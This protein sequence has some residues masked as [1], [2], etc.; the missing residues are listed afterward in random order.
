MEKLCSTGV[1]SLIVASSDVLFSGGDVSKTMYFLG[2]GEM[3]YFTEEFIHSAEVNTEEFLP[4]QWACEMTLWSEW[5]TIGTL[6]AR[7]DC[8]LTLISEEQFGLSMLS[9]DIVRSEAAVFVS[10]YIKDLRRIGR[11]RLTDI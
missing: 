7:L 2:E 6:Q 1:S 8:E 4:N 11:D 3:T 10:R 9:D 5:T